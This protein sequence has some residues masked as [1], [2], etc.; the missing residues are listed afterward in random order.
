MDD[1]LPPARPIGRA[2]Q[3]AGAGA[4]PDAGRLRSGGDGDGHDRLRRAVRLAR[5]GRSTDPASGRDAR[6]FRQRMDHER[7]DRRLGRARAPALCMA[8]GVVLRRLAA[9]S[10]RRVPVPGSPDTGKREHRRGGVPQGAELRPGVPLSPEQTAALVRDHGLAR[11][12]AAKLLGAR[13]R[14]GVGARGGSRHQLRAASVPAA[15]VAF[16]RRRSAAFLRLAG[17]PEH[18]RVSQGSRA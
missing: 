18:V 15:L 7:A 12:V 14:D 4:R 10:A 17:G 16:A 8:A 13:H 2:D 5:T 9:D 6:A 3:H 11:A 1:R